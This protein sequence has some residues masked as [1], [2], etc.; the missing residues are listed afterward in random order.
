MYIRDATI[1]KDYAVQPSIKQAQLFNSAYTVYDDVWRTH[2]HV[3]PSHLCNARCKFC[4]E[5]GVYHKKEN[6]DY[7]FQSLS[8]TLHEM[9]Q[10]GILNTVSIS[11]GEPT[12]YRYLEKVV[13]IINE[14]PVFLTM[15]TNGSNLKNIG[16]C[17]N[18]FDVINI[19][20]HYTDDIL[21]DSVFK[22]SVPHLDDILAIREEFPNVKIR[23]QAV[24]NET[25]DVQ[26]F[27]R[28]VKSGYFDDLSFRQRMI[29]SESDFVHVAAYRKL[30]DYALNNGEL[31]WQEIQDYYVY[32]T[33]RVNNVDI[34]FSY[35]NMSEAKKFDDSNEN[36]NF[37][38]EFILRPSGTLSSSWD[39]SNTQRIISDERI[40]H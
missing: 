19:S 30:I 7:F 4:I 13:N 22:T 1:G 5:H 12:I 10:Q 29:V 23:C 33:H 2:L 38:R 39:E 17:I 34:T 14:Y 21:N 27:I 32:E 9:Y 6:T 35:S 31:L 26:D 16:T 11:G 3:I 25:T 36:Q 28:L 24:V 8:R 37:I 20:R 40:F 15:N 18:G